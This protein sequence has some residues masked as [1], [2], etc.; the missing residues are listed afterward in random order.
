M[1]HDEGEYCEVGV[2]LHHWTESLIKVDVRSSSETLKNPLSLVAFES[3]ISLKLVGDDV[4]AR[5]RGTR[6]QVLLSR[7]A[8]CSTSIASHQ[9]GL[10]R[11]VL[12]VRGT[13]DNVL[14]W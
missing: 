4:G 7:R 11:A 6:P 10:T 2:R 12:K 3:S 1:G 9:F 5:G 14:A 8:E 13:G